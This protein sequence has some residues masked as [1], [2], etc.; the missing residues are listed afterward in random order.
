VQRSPDTTEFLG[1]DVFEKDPATFQWKPRLEEGKSN[2]ELYTK[3]WQ[4]ISG[5]LYGPM[6]K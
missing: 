3:Y 5:P 1:D 2:Q 4:D 6:K